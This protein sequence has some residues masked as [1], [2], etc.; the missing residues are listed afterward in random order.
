[1]SRRV[2]EKYPEVDDEDVITA[3]RNAIAIRNR[4]Y[5]PPD[6]YVAAGADSK[7]RM[8]EMPGVELEDGTLRIV[9]AMRL[10][11]EMRKELG[12]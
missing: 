5:S 10:Q 9:H 2:H 4:T 7:G 12:L 3:W 1:M 6:Y 8:L 11:D